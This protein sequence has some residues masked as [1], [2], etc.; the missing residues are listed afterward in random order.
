MH[1]F[2]KYTIYQMYIVLLPA[3]FFAQAPDTLW[4][5]TYGGFDN[6]IAY[7]V[8]E[9][10]DGKYLVAGYT[11]SFG[12]GLQD[13]YLLKID[14]DGD[15]LWTKTFGGSSMDGA[16][17]V[18][19]TSDGCYLIAGYT[20]SFG[21]GGKDMYLIKTDSAGVI[22]WTKV[23]G[24]VNQD[25]AY[26]LCET[27]DSGYII[28][29][30]RDGPS[31]WVKGDLWLLRTDVH[32]DTILTKSYGG[33]GEDYGVS[34]HVT[35]DAQCIIAGITSSFGA[36]GKDVWLLKVDT[37][38]DTLW[39]KTYG[40]T[41]EDVGYGVSPTGDG[42][43]IVT[44]YINGSGQWTAGD[45]WLLRTDASGDTQWTEVYGGAGEDFGFDVF[46]AVDNGYIIAGAGWGDV[47]LLRTDVTGDTIWT[48][49]YGGSNPDASLALSI[50]SDGG[51]IIGGWTRSFGAGNADVYLIKTEPDVGIKEENTTHVTTRQGRGTIISGPLHLPAH[52][53]CTVYDIMGERVKPD[54]ISP[55]VYFIEIDKKIIQKIIKIR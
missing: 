49:T 26:S 41:R 21:S 24:G 52:T 31:G 13:A 12:A 17:F 11:S 5:K 42:G 46:P 35:P 22:Q 53:Q 3:L 47:W 28:S 39:T 37:N 36:G 48:K 55:G 38:G 44:G 30:Y 33:V 14:D 40:E 25:V 51:Y 29:G 2:C 27:P 32:G 8:S 43:Y 4:T 1:V 9:T 7:S 23:Y 20:E 15:T 50:T 54:A 18:R 10:S 34:I 6:D 19:E 45:V 16:H